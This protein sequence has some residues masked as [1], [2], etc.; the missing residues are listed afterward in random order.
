MCIRD[1]WSKSLFGM[2]E[3]S[4]GVGWNYRVINEGLEDHRRVSCTAAEPP[5]LYYFITVHEVLIIWLCYYLVLKIIHVFKIHRRPPTINCKI[6][7]VV[8]LPYCHSKQ[9]YACIWSSV[10]LHRFHPLAPLAE[11]ILQSVLCG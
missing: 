7:M 3:Q 8:P 2:L 5:S 11:R 10:H 9:I 1:I 4:L 6:T